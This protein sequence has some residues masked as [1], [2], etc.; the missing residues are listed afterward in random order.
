M[1][2]LAVPNISS[3]DID[4]VIKTLLSGRLVQGNKVDEVEKIFS[5][6]FSNREVILVSSGFAALH[7]SLLAIGVSP[8]DEVIVPAYS[9]IATAN[10]V[11]L[12]GA[13]PIFAD[14]DYETLNLDLTHLKKLISSRTKA[15]MPV[16]EFGMPLKIDAIRKEIGRR[17]I[18]IVE[19]AACALGTTINGEKVGDL[20]SIACFSFHPRKII[21]CG[22]GGMI[23]TNNKKITEIV[24]SLRNHGIKIDSK[25]RSY[26]RAGYNYRMTELQASLLQGQMSRL[27]DILEVRRKIAEIYLN[28]IH[29]YK[30]TLPQN[31]EEIS[32]NWQTFAITMNHRI[33]TPKLI[34]H[35]KKRGIEASLAAQ[36]MPLE[37]YYRKKYNYVQKAFL[38]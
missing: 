32:R 21:T 24:R 22:E 35:L 33:D 8:G 16:H 5:K 26:I 12:C 10:A 7:L 34:K 3:S 36:C 1:I 19:D 37:P 9:F 14:I 2:K 25:N 28:N 13:T 31:P 30:F 20:G 27:S 18:Q 38:I 17:N 15:I 6:T 23:V 4:S 29:N 11:E